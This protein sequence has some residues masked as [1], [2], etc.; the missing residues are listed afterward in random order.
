MS[1]LE[2]YCILIE[3]GFAEYEAVR[4]YLCHAP[5][6]D[7]PIQNQNNEE[8]PGELSAAISGG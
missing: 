4:K 6:T 5:I 3:V 7:A 1:L 8:F 2:R